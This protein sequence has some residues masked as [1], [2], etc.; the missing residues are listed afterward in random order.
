[1]SDTHARTVASVRAA[2]ADV[3]PGAYYLISSV[4]LPAGGVAAPVAARRLR[5]IADELRELARSRDYSHATVFVLLDRAPE[6]RGVLQPLT[7]D[8]QS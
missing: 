8:G 1:M 6:R 2:F 3:P 4:T 5:E 7:G